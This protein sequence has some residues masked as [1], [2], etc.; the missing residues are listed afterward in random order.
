MNW[1]VSPY[2]CIHI[3]IKD[4]PLL[5]QIQETLGVGIVRSNSKSTAV[6]RVNSMKELKVIIDHF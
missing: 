3:H 1:R 6:F 4:L 5:K 2:F